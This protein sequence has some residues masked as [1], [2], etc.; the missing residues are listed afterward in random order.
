MQRDIP[1]NLDIQ[2]HYCENLKFQ[3]LFHCRNT[4]RLQIN[5]TKFCVLQ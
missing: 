1:E 3:I 4:N 2:Q 5:A